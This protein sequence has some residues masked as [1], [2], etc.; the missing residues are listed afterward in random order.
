MAGVLVHE[1][2]SEHGG[3]ENV[4]DEIVA[5]FPDAHVQCLWNDTGSDRYPG[6]KIHETWLARS[7]MR[8]SKALALPFMPSV[9]RNLPNRGYEWAVISSH[10]FAHQATFRGAANDFRKY[11]YVHTPAR[12]IWTP[13]LDLRGDTPTIRAASALLKPLDK[14]RAA[15]ATAIAANSQFVQQRI[16]ETWEMD[17]TV[18]YP[19]VNTDR[20]LAVDDWRSELSGDEL[21]TLE[22]IPADFILGASRF[23][24]YKRLDLVIDAGAALG[25]PVVI[26]GRGPAEQA[27]RA[28]ASEASVP[29]H[30]VISPSDAMLYA[31]YQATQVYVFPP[32]E[33]FGI[34]PVEAMACGARVVVNSVG[35]ARESVDALSRGRVFEEATPAGVS[36]AIVKAQVLSTDPGL[37][38]AAAQFSPGRFRQQLVGFVDPT[39][40]QAVNSNATVTR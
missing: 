10:L 37:R 9:W 17:A 27:L 16:A 40:R 15:E 26:A 22:A 12:Y 8:R 2:I 25:I 21:R 38:D 34:M 39:D 13:Q 30:F 18:I 1:W 11:V 33:D 36:E 4:F 28:K 20:I 14:R 35:G 24:P 6:R 3:S 31:L 19:P 32:I 29:V 5:A 7:P 23:I